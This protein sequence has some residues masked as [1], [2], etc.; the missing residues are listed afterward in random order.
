MGRNDWL[1]GSKY[2]TNLY[3]PGELNLPERMKNVLE[4]SPAPEY[5]QVVT[6][7]SIVF[8]NNPQTRL[9]PRFPTILFIISKH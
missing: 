7:V 3:R 4:M 8:L 2:N 9:V 6:W 1:T 5:A